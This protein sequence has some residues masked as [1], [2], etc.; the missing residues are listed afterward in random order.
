MT[1]IAIIIG[2]TRPCR[3][4]ES[5]ARWVHEHAAKR[6]GVEYE[7]VDLAEWDL[8]HLDEPMPAA[9]GQY[10]NDHTKAWA[11][12]IAE[13]DGYLFVTPE[14]NHSTSGALKNAIDFVGAEWYNKAAGFVSYGV[15]GGAR[16]VEHLRLVLSQLQVATVSAFVGL[17][18]QHD[19]E[20]WALKPTAGA[21]A[22]LT[23]LFDQLESW[24]AALATVRG[25][26]AAASEEDEAA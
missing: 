15:F 20:N 4:G 5:V 7:L 17:S 2:S 6:D 3:N 16:A 13:F 23:P 10:A 14:Y 19:F 24:S 9:M 22:G 11:A 25:A 26:D 21:E 8:P 18:L 1:R 12:K